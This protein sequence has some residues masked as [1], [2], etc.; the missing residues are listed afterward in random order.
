MK[1]VYLELKPDAKP[2]HGKKF[3]DPFIHKETLKKEVERLVEIGVLQRQPESPWASPT[4][5][6]PKKNLTVENYLIARHVIRLLK[7][8]YSLSLSP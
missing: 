2:C 5:I 8:S 4:F 6:I 1:P 7:L 3:P